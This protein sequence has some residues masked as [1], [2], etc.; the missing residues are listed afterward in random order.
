MNIYLTILLQF[1]LLSSSI[2]LL[3]RY[4]N[5]LGLAPLYLFLGSLQYLQVSSGTMISFTVLDG[6]IIYPGSI[7]IFSAA[8][9]ALLLIY[10]KEGVASARALIFGVVIAN[11]LLSL[12]FNV[13]HLQEASVL[14]SDALSTSLYA[15]DYKYFITGTSLLIIDFFLLVII[16]QFLVLKIRKEYF[17]L[18]LFISLLTVLVFDAF[19]FNVLL[20]YDN[21]EFITLL[22]GQIIGKSIS[23]FIFAG[24]LYVYLK[25]LDADTSESTFIANKDRDILSIFLY[26]KQYQDLKSEKKEIEQKLTSQIETTL[27]NV[28]DGFISLD[29]DWRYTFLNKQAAQFLDKTPEELIGKHIWTEF[30]DGV[31]KPFYKAYYKAFKTQKAIYLEDYYEPLDKWFESRIYPTKDGLTVYYT[32]ITDKKKAEKISEDNKVYLENI[33]N[34]IADPVFVK[35]DQS[36]FLLANT[37]FYKFFSRT[38]EEIIGKKFGRDVS[39]EERERYLKADKH[40]ISKGTEHTDIIEFKRENGEKRYISTKKTRFTDNEDNIF[41]VGVI[42]DITEQKL[43]EARIIKSE[44][45]L[46]SIINNIGDPLFVKDENSRLLL[47]NDAFC[48]IFNLS[49]V[50]IIGKTLAEHVSKEE[51]EIFLKVDKEVLNTGVENINEETLSIDGKEKK[52]ISTKKTRFIDENGNKILIGI[53][54]DVTQRRLAEEELEN[55]KTQLEELVEARTQEVISKNEELLRMNKLFVGRELKMKDL[56]TKIKR[57]LENK[58]K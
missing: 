47:V 4:R 52:I 25:Y 17:F 54:R 44:Q 29:T 11:L 18:T 8:L 49:R 3:F 55:Y 57:L 10:I 20:K 2:L 7:L 9:F 40:V 35:D 36:R 16:Y 26:K 42:R 48:T 56:K 50:E 19:L 13:S 38:K 33:I 32:D 41:L 58:D 39:L 21:S 28:S 43:A 12:L 5:V 45:Y 37:A 14:N 51:Q 22:S 53:I 30:P 24:L 27:N 31:G 34:T 6:I 15:I 1:L 23:A 46:N